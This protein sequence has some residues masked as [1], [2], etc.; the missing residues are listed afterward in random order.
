MQRW[1]PFPL[2]P[3]TAATAG[4][5]TASSFFFFFLHSSERAPLPSPFLFR[6]NSNGVDGAFFL[7]HPLIWNR[8]RESGLPF[9]FFPRDRNP[10]SPVRSSSFSTFPLRR[11]NAECVLLCLFSS[12]RC[13]RTLASSDLPFLARAATRDLFVLFTVEG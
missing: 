4:G 11:F 12:L 9:F 2:L 7:S 3:V 13:P 6:S 1:D 10:S 5:S 8:R